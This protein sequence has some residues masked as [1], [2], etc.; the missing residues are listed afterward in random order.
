MKISLGKCQIFRHLSADWALALLV[1]VGFTVAAAATPR[2][3]Q[4]LTRT[5][6]TGTSWVQRG[7][8]VS[9]QRAGNNIR[10]ERTNRSLEALTN[11]IYGF[12]PEELLRIEV[13]D[14]KRVLDA[15]CGDGAFVR[16][17]RKKGIAALGIDI[18]LRIPQ[19]LQPQLF[20]QADL[21]HTGFPSESFDV[22]TSTYSL[23][24]YEQNHPEVIAGAVHELSRLLKP[25]GQVLISPYYAHEFDSLEQVRE[26]FQTEGFDVEV[27][28]V[29]KGALDHHKIWMVQAH[30]I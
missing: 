9:I 21:S 17:L 25:G 12:Y 30:K 6:I 28:A 27:H 11:P 26:L 5:Q 23:F 24:S 10:Y 4:L 8:V 29:R 18:A 7:Q 1:T 19:K 2:C 13:L 15:G 14:G 20:R 22:I 16:D 3:E